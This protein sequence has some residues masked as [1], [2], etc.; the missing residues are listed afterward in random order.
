M[1]I[2]K[3]LSH[4]E[5]KE[6]SER[7]FYDH[8]LSDLSELNRVLFTTIETLEKSSIPYAI[9]G[10][11]A[12]KSLGRPRVTHDIDLFVRPDDAE[13]VLEVLEAKG[14]TTQKRDPFWLFKAWQD[15]ILV[16]VIFK[17]SGDIYFDEEVRAHVRRVPY[18]GSYVNAISPEDFLV[19]KAAAHQEHNP[20]HWHDAL[21]VLKQGNLDWDYL[22]KRAKH[23]PRRILALL[24]YGQSN[25]IAVPNEVIQK[26]YRGV[27]ESPVYMPESIV[28][29]YR[30]DLAHMSATSE[31]GTESPIYVKGKIMEALTTDE[32]IAEHDVKVV[33]SDKTIVAKGEVFT[34]EQK[35]AVNEVIHE[36]A[37]SYECKNLVN[38]RILHA[39]EG[40]EA[41]K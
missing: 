16:D 18:L 26:L 4:A 10:G 34:E 14:F 31:E 35:D 41:I 32:R 19:I 5:E 29:P 36:I 12:V 13:K 20:H 1:E 33:V 15:E 25:D 2:K 39:P 21:A 3:N 23:A 11:V 8:N 22:L 37:P 24:I 7:D 30:H 40:S 9:I 17:S 28:Y 38:V 27:F 6:Q